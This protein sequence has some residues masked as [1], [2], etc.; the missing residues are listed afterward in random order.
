MVRGWTWSALESTVLSSPCTVSHR[1]R[2]RRRG[3]NFCAC[4]GGLRLLAVDT[5]VP[6]VRAQIRAI[7]QRWTNR[8]PL[9]LTPN[10][11]LLHANRS[12]PSV[13]QCR[14]CP[15][16][17]VG[18]TLAVVDL[19]QSSYWSSL[20]VSLGRFVTSAPS[21]TCSLRAPACRTFLSPEAR[22]NASSAANPRGTFSICVGISTQHTGGLRG[23]AFTG[24]ASGRRPQIERRCSVRCAVRRHPQAS[25]G[26]L[27]EAVIG[28]RTMMELL[29]EVV[30]KLVA[31]RGPGPSRQT[32]LA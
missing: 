15:P 28:Q 26:D 23:T 16:S 2:L 4:L 29:T 27:P 1:W 8:E 7:R 6:A 14:V 25:E 13:G 31:W 21:R 10:C 19:T 17:R 5:A 22:S 3:V 24:T 30:I 9:C 32:R 11:L 12:W 20:C 18:S